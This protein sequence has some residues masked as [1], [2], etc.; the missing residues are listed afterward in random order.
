MPSA[1]PAPAPPAKHL[2]GRGALFTPLRLGFVHLVIHRFELTLLRSGF[3]CAGGALGV[4]V[5]RER[6]VAQDELDT[7]AVVSA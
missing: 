3:D 1:P 2:I 4:E 5:A 7:V 6:E